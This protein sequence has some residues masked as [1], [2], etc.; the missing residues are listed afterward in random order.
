MSVSAAVFSV[1]IRNSTL[2]SRYPGGVEAYREACPNGTFCTDG[3]ITRIGF[4][5]PEDAHAFISGLTP[6]G[7]VP[8]RDGVAA[9]I[10][11]ADGAGGFVYP[12]DWLD[13]A[14]HKDRPIVWLAGEEPDPLYVPA[15]EW[16]SEKP[17]RWVSRE[18][19]H[20]FFE[21]VRAEQN[22]EAYRDRRTG[23]VLYIGR[24]TL[25]RSRRKWWQ[26]WK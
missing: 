7:L 16:G 24:P 18:D 15:V 26:L 1:V 6:T 25:P 9:D 20:K 13:A 19:F 14:L 21:F 11:L 2:E 22:V 4:M 3:R 8:M 12:C 5:A 23:E 10:A 17:L